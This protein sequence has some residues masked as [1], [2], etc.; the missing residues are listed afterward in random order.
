MKRINLFLLTLVSMFAFTFGVSA[1][2]VSNEQEFIDAVKTDNK[3][4]LVKDIT[5]ESDLTINDVE[6]T[7]DLNGHNISLENGKRLKFTKGSLE[8]TGTGVIEEVERV[9]AVLTVYGS[10]NADDNNYSVLTI[11][12]DVTI[13]G[14]HSVMVGATAKHAYGVVINVNGKLDANEFTNIANAVGTGI[15]INGTINDASANAPVINLNSTAIVDGVYAAGFATMNVNGAS[16]EGN[17]GIEIRSGILNVNGGTIRGTAIPTETTPNGNGSTTEGA[18]IAIVQHD[19]KNIIKVTVTKGLIEGYTAF[20]QNNTQ[21]NDDASVAKITLAI[22]GG[23]FNAINGGTNAV[24]SENFGEFVTNGTFNKEVDAKYLAEKTVAEKSGENYVV[25][26]NVKAE[27]EGVKFESE[28]AFSKEY[29]LVVTPKSDE[30]VKD[31]TEKLTDAYKDNKKVTGL[32][33][34]SLQDIS[35]VVDGEV[36]VMENGKYTISIPVKEEL[37]NFATYKVI[38]VSHDGE[39][40]ETIDAKLVDGKVVFTTTHLSTYGVIGYNAPTMNP[41]TSDGII[42]YVAIMCASVLAIG[43]IV[44]LRKRYN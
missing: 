42:S 27:S 31:V 3:I 8:I 19:T 6:I 24:Y 13:K 10:T 18:G 1:L 39:I 30:D 28:E 14:A 26:P 36:V 33:L 40:E 34:I 21:K 29:T 38:Y 17:T 2:D 25:K 7:L 35:M 5:L 22:N 23:T 16:I 12:K 4:T 44:T 9:T 37:R 43:T 32:K 11:G 15:Y 20:Y 41:E